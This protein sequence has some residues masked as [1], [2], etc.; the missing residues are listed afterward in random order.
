MLACFRQGMTAAMTALKIKAATGEEPAERTIGRRMSEWRAEEHRRKLGREQMQDLLEA[1]RAGNYVASEMV[2]ALS[3][4]ALLRDPEG[5]I[6]QDPI[7]AQKVS[8]KAE[9]I[10]LKRETLEVKKREQALNE[11]KFDL[12]KQQKQKVLDEA[13]ALEQKAARGETLGPEDIRRIK[14][15][16]GLS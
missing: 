1:A 15:I 10:R 12:L 9:E 13:A 16:Y 3:I 14:D 8:I 2:N 6:N 7:E 5:F 11:A 4:E